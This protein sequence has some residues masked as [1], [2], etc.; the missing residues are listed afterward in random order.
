M[1]STTIESILDTTRHLPP[2]LQ[3]E[4]AFEFADRVLAGMV[5]R[6]E[7][8]RIAGNVVDIETAFTDLRKSYG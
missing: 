4:L 3:S 8:D 2:E 1:D 5:E 6:G 7:Q